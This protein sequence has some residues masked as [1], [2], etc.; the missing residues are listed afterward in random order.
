MNFSVLVH[1]HVHKDRII[2]MPCTEP[3]KPS[4]TLTPK[5]IARVPTGALYMYMQLPVYVHVCTHEMC[6]LYMYMHVHVHVLTRASV[7]NQMKT[8][9]TGIV[10][11]F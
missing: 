5:Y 11:D 9:T 7:A 4:S 6:T 10:F 3:L 8:E 2:I 1:V